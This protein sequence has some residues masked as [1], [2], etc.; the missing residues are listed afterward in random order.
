MFPHLDSFTLQMGQLLL[1]TT[2]WLVG[3]VSHM[4]PLPRSV[5]FQYDPGS[6]LAYIDLPGIFMGRMD[7]LF[8]EAVWVF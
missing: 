1:Y 3:E 6:P 5:H 2:A 8:L 7:T 4:D